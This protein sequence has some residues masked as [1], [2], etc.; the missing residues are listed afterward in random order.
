MNVLGRR[1]EGG[2]SGGREEGG[3]D[4]SEEKNEFVFLFFLVLNFMFLL[5]GFYC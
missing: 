4:K 5:S 3:E 2:R 1:W